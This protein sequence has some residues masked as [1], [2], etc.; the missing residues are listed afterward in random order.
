MTKDSSMTGEEVI[1]RLHN[2]IE[3]EL[4]KDQ[5]SLH[6]VLLLRKQIKT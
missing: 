4:L 2:R 3:E 6:E 5:E 1:E